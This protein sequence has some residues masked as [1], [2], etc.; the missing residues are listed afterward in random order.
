MPLI[1]AELRPLA[2]RF[3]LGPMFFPLLNDTPTVLRNFKENRNSLD[4]KV[5][6]WLGETNPFAHVNFRLVRASAFGRIVVAP[7]SLPLHPPLLMLSGNSSILIF[8]N[9]L[10]IRFRTRQTDL[11]WS[12]I[13]LFLVLLFFFFLSL[14]F[15]LTVFFFRLTSLRNFRE[16]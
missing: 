14:F 12:P 5:G 3:C 11:V 2:Y 9:N 16:G 10:I 8:R 4:I 1:Y 7:L 13:C 6:P 15:F